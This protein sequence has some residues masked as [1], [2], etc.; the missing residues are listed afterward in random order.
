MFNLISRALTP[1]T[2]SEQETRRHIIWWILIRVF[3]FTV[4]AGITLFFQ[5]KGYSA[6]LPPLPVTATFL[7]FL[8]AFSI[9]SALL[10]QKRPWSGRRFGVIQLL[11]DTLFTA[12]LVY[13]TGCSQS[14]FAPLLILPVI[15]GGLILYKTGGLILASAATLIYGAVLGCEYFGWVPEYFMTA[16]YLAPGTLFPI[17]NLFAIY[18]LIFFLAALLSG[19]LARRL[20]FTE[21]KLSK[22]ALEYDRLSILYKQIFDDISTGI[23]TTDQGDF[24]TSYNQAAER[25]TGYPLEEILGQPFNRC[26]S[27]ITLQERQGRCVCN[28]QKFEGSVIRIGYSFSYLNMPV[29]GRGGDR[30]AQWKVITLQDISQIEQM[31]RQM[32]EAEKMAAIGELSAS[33]AHDF[34]NPLAAISGSAQILTMEQ[35]NIAA[36]DPATFRTLLNIILRESNRMAKTITDFL[37]FARPAP[38][39]HEWFDLNRLIDEVI[40]QLRSASNTVAANSIRKEIAGHLACWAD[41]QQMQTILTHLLD[42][43][44]VAMGGQPGTVMIAGRESNGHSPG[45]I[46]VEICDQGPGIPIELREKVFMPFFSTRTDGTGLGLA[47]VRQI[48]ENHQGRIEIDR[49]TEYNCIMRITLPLPKITH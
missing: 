3:L 46:C 10:L 26:F 5:E 16:S 28:F 18:G 29:A 39:H 45:G 2:D 37:Q 27:A 42:N 23:I 47:I 35:A 30:Q 25:I 9:G 11:A 7:A 17:T 1:V 31:E 43:A 24:I 48:I 12:L 32:R 14:V 15:A 33:I 19:Q 44:C 4:L 13:A 41:R 49:S 20:R 36:L 40:A 38:I 21:E 34:R 6:I 22:T 8:Y